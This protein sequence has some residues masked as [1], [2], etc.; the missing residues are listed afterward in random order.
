MLDWKWLQREP[1]QKTEKKIGKKEINEMESS[2]SIPKEQP[3]QY[4]Q[5]IGKHANSISKYNNNQRIF[6]KYQ[7][8]LYIKF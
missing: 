8:N 7:V 4:L 1:T 5:F 2:G 6:Y 3:K